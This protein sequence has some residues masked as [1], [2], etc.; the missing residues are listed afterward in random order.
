MIYY[1]RSAY[2]NREVPLNY[3]AREYYT[4]NVYDM[5]S[6]EEILHSASLYDSM[7]DQYS[8]KVVRLIKEITIGTPEEAYI[9]HVKCG[10]VDMLKL[11]EHYDDKSTLERL[12]KHAREALNKLHYRHEHTFTFQN[13]INALQINFQ[14]L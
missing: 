3:V 5:T 4:G 11:Q 13:Y 14:G 8:K 2:N 1:L 9:K 7:I 12:E 6:E 10:C